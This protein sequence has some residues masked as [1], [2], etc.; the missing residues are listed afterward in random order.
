MID[1][2]VVSLKPAQHLAAGFRRTQVFGIMGENRTVPLQ[3]TRRVAG[4]GKGVAQ[5]VVESN[6]VRADARTLA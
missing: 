1:R 3:G 2:F 4:P 6:V 5:V